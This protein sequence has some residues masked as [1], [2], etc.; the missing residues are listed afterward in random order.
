MVAM[1]IDGWLNGAERG[2]TGK[3]GLV[4]RSNDGERELG[5]GGIPGTRR[6]YCRPMM[7]LVVMWRV[8]SILQHEVADC[9]WLL[10]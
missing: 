7:I 1:E 2:G 9:F 6:F 10:C 5:N 8:T 3:I 4:Q